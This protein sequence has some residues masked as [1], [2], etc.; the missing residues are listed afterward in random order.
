MFRFK[1]SFFRFEQSI[2]VVYKPLFESKPPDD[3]GLSLSSLKIDERHTYIAKIARL[4]N[5][6]ITKFET[7]ENWSFV[8]SMDLMAYWHNRDENM[9]IQAVHRE[10]AEKAKSRYR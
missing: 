7:V 3:D 4:A 8:Q 1:R 9:K 5:D 10:A 2:K 6:D